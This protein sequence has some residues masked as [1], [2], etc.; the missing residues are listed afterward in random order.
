M[1]TRHARASSVDSGTD[2]REKACGLLVVCACVNVPSSSA[3]WPG[4]LSRNEFHA[5]LGTLSFEQEIAVVCAGCHGNLCATVV[6]EALTRGGFRRA[7]VLAP[8]DPRMLRRSSAHA[9]VGA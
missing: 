3:P 1:G 2:G 5:R 6:V 4:A 8:P 9:T 7:R